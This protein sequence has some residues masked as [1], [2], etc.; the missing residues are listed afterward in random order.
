MQ[1]LS[2]VPGEQRGTHSPSERPHVLHLYMGC[3][4]K[5]WS[6][7][8]SSSKHSNE[9]LQEQ[10]CYTCHMILDS[11]PSTLPVLSQRDTAL[12]SCRRT[13][14]FLSFSLTP[15]FILHPCSQ[16]PQ[17]PCRA[18]TSGLCPTTVYSSVSWWNRANGDCL[19]E[20]LF[21]LWAQAQRACRPACSSQTKGPFSPVLKEG[22][23]D[24]GSE[25][26]GDWRLEKY[27]F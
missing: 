1:S 12:A 17:D 19:P 8:D 3:E 4:L 14:A 9:A 27:I 23:G 10:R 6:R 26:V 15:Y 7:L 22:T 18:A 11:V 24:S 2:P 25:L 20:R 21:Q 16:W 13:G 5:V